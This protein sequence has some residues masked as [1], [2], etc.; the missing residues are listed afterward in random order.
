M[1]DSNANYQKMEEGQQDG[2]MQPPF[3]LT[4]LDAKK[5]QLLKG[6]TDAQ[7]KEMEEKY[8]LNEVP[9]HKTPLWKISSNSSQV[10]CKS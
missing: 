9:E 1:A 6:L 10:L 7:A 8:G 2:I 5:E 3:P 4:D